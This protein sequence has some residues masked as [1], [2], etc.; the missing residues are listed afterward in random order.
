MEQYLYLDAV[1]LAAQLLYGVYASPGR[2]LVEVC[3]Q[4]TALRFKLFF[5]LLQLHRVGMEGVE[6]SS[7]H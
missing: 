2:S 4:V 5:G 3:Q 6:P 1:Q 7:S